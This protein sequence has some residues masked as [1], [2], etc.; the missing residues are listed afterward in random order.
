MSDLTPRE[1]E[2][3]SLLV[4]G[5]SNK[6]IASTLVI[7]PETVRTHVYHITAKLKVAN[8]TA[9]AVRLYAAGVRP[10]SG[11]SFPGQSAAQEPTCG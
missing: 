7:E 3:A 1:R 10:T 9:A 4:A 6:E 2:V 8:R 11:R 5:L